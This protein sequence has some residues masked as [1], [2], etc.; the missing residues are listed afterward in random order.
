MT[1]CN[2]DYGKTFYFFIIKAKL[3]F[4]TDDAQ[5]WWNFMQLVEKIDSNMVYQVLQENYNCPVITDIVIHFHYCV[6]KLNCK[7]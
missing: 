1:I 4:V 3:D 2:L 7:I 5:H 6:V